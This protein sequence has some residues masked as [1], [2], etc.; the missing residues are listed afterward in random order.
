VSADRPDPDAFYRNLFTRNPEWSSRHPNI[1]E[2]ARAAKV[3]P[4]LSELA[5]A[6]GYGRDGELRLLDLGCGRG[7]L[8]HLASVYGDCLGI[9]PVES[10]TEYAAECFPHLAFRCAT[11]RSLLDEGAREGF[12][13]V[14]SSEVI[15]HVPRINRPEWVDEIGMLLREDGVAVVTSDRGEQYER[16]LRRGVT[17]QPEEDW[18]TER[19]LRE[20]FE[21]RGFSAVYHDRA[22]VDLPNMSRLH[23]VLSSR[24]FVR[25]LT[26]ARQQWLLEGLRF[27]AA[28]CQV[29]AFRK[30]G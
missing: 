18:L 1:E 7:W 28:N 6:R 12:D 2:A 23:R 10:V 14:L 20:L 16:W 22:Y 26:R 5:H 11:A 21:G 30:N 24:R 3:L 13:V 15:E 19:E 8:T 17:E 29:W 4:L 9:D 27:H 25:L